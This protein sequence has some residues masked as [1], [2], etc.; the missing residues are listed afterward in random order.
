MR[1]RLNQ[2][3]PVP[4]GAG[5]C[6]RSAETQSGVALRFPPQSKTLRVAACRSRAKSLEGNPSVWLYHPMTKAALEKSNH[7]RGQA[8]NRAS[9]AAEQSC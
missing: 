1:T 7:A 8:R 9:G 4:R 3:A 6:A 5:Q 2:R